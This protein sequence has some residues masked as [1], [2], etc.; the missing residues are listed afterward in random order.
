VKT[1]NP[2]ANASPEFA[3]FRGYVQAHGFVIDTPTI[4][5][6]EALNR[7]LGLMND[8]TTI[9]LLPDRRWV[10]I[11]ERIMNVRSH[12][13]PG[14]ALQRNRGRLI[15]A[16]NPPQGPSGTLVLY[17]AGRWEEF[18]PAALPL[19]DPSDWIDLGNIPVHV[20]TALVTRSAPIATPVDR[21][22]VAK[23]P[24]TR[25]AA[26]I[27]E[28]NNKVRKLLDR[29]ITRTSTSSSATVESW[30]PRRTF[31]P[32]GWL[33]RRGSGSADEIGTPNSQPGKRPT[34]HAQP[35]RDAFIRALLRTPVT[36]RLAQKHQ[37]YI[38]NLERLF[39]HGNLDEALRNAIGLGATETTNLSLALPS[40]RNSLSV[41]RWAQTSARAVPWGSD[42]HFSLQER[43]RQAAIQLEKQ[44]RIHEAVFVYVELL[45]AIDEGIALL[46]RNADWR[47]AA[48]LAEGHKR[49]PAMQI[50]LWWKAGERDHAIRIA[51]HHGAFEDA[52]TFA[53]RS[54]PF[55]ASELRQ[56]WVDALSTAGAYLQAVQ[57]AWPD[58]HL[59]TQTASVIE[60]GIAMGGPQAATLRAYRLSAWPSEANRDEALGLLSSTDP[61]L[62]LDRQMF[63]QTMATLACEDRAIDRQISTAS[64][65]A[66]MIISNDGR[67]YPNFSQDVQHFSSRCDPVLRADLTASVRSTN[68]SAKGADVVRIGFG[69]H[70]ETWTVS[71]VAPL[72]NGS[73]LIARGQLG[74]RLINRQGNVAA[75]WSNPATDIVVADHGNKALLLNRLHDAVEVHQLN[76]VDRRMRYWAT[77]RLRQFTDTYDGDSWITMHG[78]GMAVFDTSAPQPSIVWKELAATDVVR[79]LQRSSEFLSAAVD[80]DQ[81]GPEIWKWELPGFA[82]RSRATW[83]GQAILADG[84]T[85]TFNNAEN[86][87]AVTFGS[88]S[89]SYADLEESQM[90]KP[91][92]IVVSGNAFAAITEVGEMDGQRHGTTCEAHIFCG[93]LGRPSVVVVGC[94]NAPK[95]RRVGDRIAFVN[96]GEIVTFDCRDPENATVTLLRE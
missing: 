56:H 6:R 49:P 31:N 35:I 24:D 46:E 79:N 62:R 61:E 26:N 90:R 30:A 73:L 94:G 50:R 5:E 15:S 72:P 54:D 60:A 3:T 39:E 42:V 78:E 23:V 84:R 17:T 68:R 45:A 34:Q 57:A 18:Q 13:A 47:F 8:T 63:L 75:Q 28:P 86:V 22:R 85:A 4:G 65:R 48:E 2:P 38:R 16:P 10:L 53:N 69:T 91:I 70:P 77:I 25:A 58:E 96:G 52:I 83:A 33:R 41:S 1:S 64:L 74:V 81:P 82:L 32:F 92:A 21:T 71:D 67:W 7:V 93:Y 55:L 89:Y 66:L 43:Y 12:A 95:I 11:S 51:K 88:F 87:T 44:Q 40:P 36:N 59:R 19:I 76:L 27:G 20:L 14:L 80:H 29:M 37:R 9:R